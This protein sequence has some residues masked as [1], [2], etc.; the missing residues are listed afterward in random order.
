MRSHCIR[1]GVWY[2]FYMTHNTAHFKEKIEGELSLLE[3]ELKRVGRINPSNPGDWEA[4]PEKED[5]LAAD[6]NEVADNIRDYEGNAAILKQLEIRYNALKNALV[7]IDEGSY[8]IC[9]VCGK[10]IETERLEADPSAKTCIEHKEES[11][12]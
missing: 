1:P 11:T 2:D 6:R 10:E 12:A 8:G 4:T 9:A 7:Q 3:V 5:T